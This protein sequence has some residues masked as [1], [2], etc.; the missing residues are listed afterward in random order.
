MAPSTAKANGEWRV[1]LLVQPRVEVV[2][3][4]HEVESDLSGADRLTD[5]L[6]R[7]ERLRCQLVPDLHRPSPPDNDVRPVSSVGT[8]PRARTYFAGVGAYSPGW[9]HVR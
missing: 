9:C 5:D 6:L 3:H 4:L 8:V 2:A 7:S 1:A